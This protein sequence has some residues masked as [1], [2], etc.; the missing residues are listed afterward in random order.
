MKILLNL[1]DL[2]GATEA[3]LL[4]LPTTPRRNSVQ[5][6]E[7]LVIGHPAIP[8]G[9]CFMDPSR[10]WAVLSH[11]VWADHIAGSSIYR[12]TDQAATLP[13]AAF[14]PYDV[15][16]WRLADDLEMVQAGQDPSF[17]YPDRE[18]F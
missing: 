1:E 6:G 11:E 7:A 2:T 16:S 3:A 17:W 12:F 14:L 10:A 4:A 18:I 8:V 9:W 13:L 5:M 15:V